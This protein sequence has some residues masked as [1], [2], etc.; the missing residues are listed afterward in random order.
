MKRDSF[1][2]YKSF[3]EAISEA[4]SDE[5]LLI[6]RAIANYALYHEEPDLQGVAKLAWLLIKPQLDANWKRF[7]NGCNGGA[8]TGNSNAQKQPRNNRRST[9]NQPRINQE[10]TDKQPRNNHH[11]QKKH[12]NGKVNDND[13]VNDNVNLSLYKGNNQTEL[14]IFLE[15]LFFEKKY[16]N[17][18]AELNRF[19]A[20]YDKTDWIDKNGNKVKNKLSALKAWTPL[21]EQTKIPTQLLI[22]Y[23]NL[24]NAI[25]TEKIGNIIFM[26]T[27][28]HS[29]KI[30]E[31][32]LTITC[33][34]H[35]MQ[36]LENA[37]TNKNVTAKFK[38]IFKNKNV[39]YTINN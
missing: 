1:I 17:P 25:K 3:H 38:E 12:A 22:P 5:Q 18:C 26:L 7:K 28:L 2:F 31:K 30:S 27:D 19:I 4:P 6:Y 9:D 14:E 32:D 36:F 39:L 29:L 24:Y 20:H 23:R 11:P 10:S 21:E 34:Q 33:T 37:F 13:N 8:P 15:Y 35:L 16:I